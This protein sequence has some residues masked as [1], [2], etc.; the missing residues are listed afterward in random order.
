MY[1][2]IYVYFSLAIRV[3]E[4]RVENSSQSWPICME[5]DDMIINQGVKLLHVLLQILAKTKTAK[6][7]VS[8]MAC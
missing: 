8:T 7:H 1:I 6:L 4:C 5:Q 3:Y 2:Y